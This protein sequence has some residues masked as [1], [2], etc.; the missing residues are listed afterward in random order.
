M[1]Q[2]LA[3][4]PLTSDMLKSKKHLIEFA[5][6]ALANKSCFEPVE[7]W[8]KECWENNTLPESIRKVPEIVK[9]S[10]CI[11]IKMGERKPRTP[12]WYDECSGKIWAS[13]LGFETDSDGIPIFNN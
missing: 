13:D 7:Q 9:L 2:E 4:F 8:K 5:R 6:T 3:N 11:I 1:G 12:K 10:M